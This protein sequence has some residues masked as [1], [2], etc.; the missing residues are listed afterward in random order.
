M[1][2]TFEIEER[3]RQLHGASIEKE[4]GGLTAMQEAE[5]LLWVLGYDDPDVGGFYGKNRS[6]TVDVSDYITV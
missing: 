1:R 3:L 6:Q 4:M 5:T 2:S